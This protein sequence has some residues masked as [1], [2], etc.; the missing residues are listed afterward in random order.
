MLYEFRSDARASLED[1]ERR[2][3][4]ALNLYRAAGI[5]ISCRLIGDRPCSG[6]VDP[7]A[8]RELEGLAAGIVREH[9][10]TELRFSPGSTDCN[11][12]LSMGVPALCV[13][14]YRG[15]GAHTRQEYVELDSLL[16]GL[17]IAFDLILGFCR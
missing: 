15:S 13:G 17:R 4:A 14:C 5:D 3:D 7:A 6:D 11:I 10:G 8:M 12:P 1:M 16:P 9:C 2:L